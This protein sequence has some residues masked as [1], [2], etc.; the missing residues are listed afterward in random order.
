MKKI[1][2]SVLLILSSIY[3][4][5]QEEANDS[6]DSN[7]KLEIY[8]ENRNEIIS[9][10][11]MVSFIE[12][13]YINNKFEGNWMRMRKGN[14]FHYFQYPHDISDAS[15]WDEWFKFYTINNSIYYYPQIKNSTKNNVGKI[16]EENLLKLEYKGDLFE[17]KPNGI[18]E[19]S[20][21]KDIY[22][23]GN[24]KQGIP[25]GEW[26][27]FKLKKI[28]GK[29]EK[30]IEKIESYKD[31]KPNGEWIEY[32]QRG[33]VLVK[34]N[35]KDGMPNGEK[36]VYYENKLISKYNFSMGLP[37]GEFIV[38]DNQYDYKF[39][40]VKC[41]YESGEFVELTQFVNDKMISKIIS[42]IIKND[43]DNLV[44]KFYME[45]INGKSYYD[46]HQVNPS[47]MGWILENNF[48]VSK[49]LF[50]KEDCNFK[51][52][53][54]PSNHNDYSIGLIRYSN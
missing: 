21:E 3:S 16:D 27:Y 11:E 8:L 43:N 44:V 10:S 31:G 30:I 32:L 24:F 19:I 39:L 42:K 50:N 36:T 4:F 25:E 35:F 15:S 54:F 26:K 41:K 9:N 53:D 18:W 34:E 46:G 6:L 40:K 14:W 47:D 2:S 48:A 29:Y 33:E 7:R 5:S 13:Y 28:N 22:V 23:V 52:N 38:Y 12:F 37:H 17:G 45:I 49:T 51:I 20:F 1:F